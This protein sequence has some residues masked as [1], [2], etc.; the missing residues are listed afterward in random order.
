VPANSTATLGGLGGAA[1]AMPR[2]KMLDLPVNQ[3]A[4]K[5]AQLA[6]SY[7]GTGQGG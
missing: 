2:V 6:L 7:A 4:C 1:S 5:S 3:D